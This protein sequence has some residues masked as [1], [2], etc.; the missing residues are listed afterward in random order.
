LLLT[1]SPYL[2]KGWNILRP[3]AFPLVYTAALGERFPPGPT[4]AATVA[5][6]QRYFESKIARSI[7][8]SLR[9]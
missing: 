6:L 1:N 5:T 7:D 8:A 4:T 9:V 2:S 3:P